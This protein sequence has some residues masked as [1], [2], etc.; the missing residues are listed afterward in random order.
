MTVNDNYST[1]KRSRGAIGDMITPPRGA[2]NLP[3]VK[4]AGGMAASHGR[5][6]IK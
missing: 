5:E 4:E 2:N 6:G 1:I 3:N